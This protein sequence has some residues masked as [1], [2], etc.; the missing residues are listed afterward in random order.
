[1]N[2]SLVPVCDR[3]SYNLSCEE[4]AVNSTFDQLDCGADPTNFT[5]AI[6]QNYRYYFDGVLVSIFGFIGI[7]GNIFTLIVL[8]RPKFKDCF[9]KLLFAL[10]CYD[11]IFIICGGINYTCRA[12]KAGST[13]FTILFPFFIH[14]F[15]YIGMSGS[16]FMTFAISIER[17]LGICY[18]LKFPPHTRK[19]WFYILPV[20]FISIVTNIPRF[21]DAV[22]VWKDGEP[23]Y[24]P[25]QFRMSESYIKMYQTYFNIP[26]SAIMPL[27]SMFFLNV[28]IIWDLKNVKVQRFGSKKKLKKE[29]NLF[30]VLLSIVVTFLIL[31]SPRIIV[32]IY[33]F[34]HV[35]IVL[36]CRKAEILF[37]PIMLIGCL[38]HVAHFTTIINSGINFI[39][40]SF[41]GNTFRREFVRLIGC[42]KVIDSTYSQRTNMSEMSQRSSPGSNQTIADQTGTYA[43]PPSQSCHSSLSKFE[44][45]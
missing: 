35:D 38:T 40:Y 18:P 15:S 25:T 10:A 39:I 32:D 26:F 45:E 20:S 16:I 13:I 24:A 19:A 37:K 29:V 43:S 28:R 11:T 4:E 44:E 9:H 6:V 12:F 5:L 21:F 30:F 31:H 34:L 3:Q 33:E 1:M 36:D 22:L 42:N 8:A 7:I 17:F 14:P 41:V 2:S 23:H 27:F